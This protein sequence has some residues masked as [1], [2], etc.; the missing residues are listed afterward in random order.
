MRHG[1]KC[2]YRIEVSRV[3]KVTVSVSVSYTA[4][5]CILYRT[6]KMMCLLQLQVPTDR[7]PDHHPGEPV[8]DDTRYLSLFSYPETLTLASCNFV[9]GRSRTDSKLISLSP[10]KPRCFYAT[11]G[12]WEAVTLCFRPVHLFVHVCMHTCLHPNGVLGDFLPVHRQHL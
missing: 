4:L 5:P 9:P 1:T 3:S 10:G 6:R 8:F 12:R 7:V 2:G 11:C